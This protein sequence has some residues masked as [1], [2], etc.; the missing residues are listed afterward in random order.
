M[1]VDED[2]LPMNSEEESAAELIE[3]LFAEWWEES[4][5][6]D[7][8]ANVTP[9][10]GWRWG[11]HVNDMARRRFRTYVNATGHRGL[12]KRITADWPRLREDQS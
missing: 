12:E 11:R 7:V 9:E 4:G 10:P 6:Q 3:R 8:F 1:R 2:G 5:I